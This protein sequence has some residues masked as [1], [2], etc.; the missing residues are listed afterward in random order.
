MRTLI[1][2]A[3]SATAVIL[4]GT[5]LLLAEPIYKLNRQQT[6]AV[7][8]SNLSPGG[9]CVDNRMAGRVISVRYNRQ[10]TLPIEFTIEQV[11][12]SRLVV[13]VDTH[14]FA[15][16]SRLAQGWVGQTL[17]EHIRKGKA[18]DLRVKLCGASGR[19]VM[20]DGL[21]VR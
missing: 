3:A 13:N 2:S 5:S 8:L 10:K 18:V 19:V 20:L 14:A 11:G 17:Q 1:R 15:E 7:Q 21:R 6:K 4:A 9:M 16:A 12:G